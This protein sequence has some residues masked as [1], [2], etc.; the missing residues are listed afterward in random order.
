MA[1]ARNLL[2]PLARRPFAPVPYLWSDRYGLK[3]QAYGRL[4]GHD[5]AV[6][7]EGSSPDGASSPPT[8]QVT[9]WPACS[10]SACRTPR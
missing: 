1:A 9:A 6:V 5:E 3:V 2:K 4:R 7:V 8:A 10:P